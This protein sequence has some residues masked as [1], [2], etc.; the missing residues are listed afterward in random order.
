[1]N[2]WIIEFN[3]VFFISV[4]TII[5][6]ATNFMIKYCYKSRCKEI[7]CCCIKVLRDPEAENIEDNQILEKG[8]GERKLSV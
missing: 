5:C 7:E 8:Q 2:D 1:M 3:A 4:L 6:G